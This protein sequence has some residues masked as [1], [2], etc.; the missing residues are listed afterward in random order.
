MET[1]AQGGHKF[2]DQEWEDEGLAELAEEVNSGP[3]WGFDDDC[4]LKASD[5]VSDFLAD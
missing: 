5:I 2:Q 4:E 1:K 3:I